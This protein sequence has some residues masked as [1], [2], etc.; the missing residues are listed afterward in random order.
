[1]KRHWAIL[2]G[3]I[4]IGWVGGAIGAER[5]AAPR[6]PLNQKQI[7][8]LTGAKGQMN[9]K[10]NVFKVSVPRSDIAAIVAGTKVTPPMGL[11]TWAAFTPS[12]GT[13]TMVMGDLVLTEDQVN[14]A[15][16]AALDNGLEVTA[17][18]NHFIWDS[19]KV[20]FMHIAGMGDEG[21]LASAVGRVFATIKQT[22]GGAGTAPRAELDPSKTNLN[23]QR[24]EAI[25]GHKG[26]LK[27]GV[28]KVTIGRTTRMHGHEVGNAM[29]VNTWAAF[30]GSD[31]RA[32]VDGDFAILET[33]LQGVLKALRHADIN[34]V[35]IHNH[36]IGEEPRVLFLHFWGVGSTANLAKGL[37][38]ALA[39]TRS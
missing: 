37:K 32:V 31:E 6:T 12:G 21:K 17:L 38:A 36:M 20:M 14:P 1:M 22:S 13:E 27:D 7:E 4:L 24:I 30:I 23:P 25:L 33:E 29:G 15:M 35:A 10:E 18:H 11:T 39:A 3:A 5:V 34:V 28:Y 8:Q 2:A 16:S 26:E 19:P 9:E